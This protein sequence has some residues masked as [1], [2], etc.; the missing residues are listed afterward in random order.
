MRHAYPEQGMC[1]NITEQQTLRD[2]KAMP[3]QSRSALKAGPPELPPARHTA[4]LR[5]RQVTA[6]SARTP[7]P[8]FRCI[9]LE[10]DWKGAGIR[11]ARVVHAQPWSREKRSW[12][13][14]AARVHELL[15]H[16]GTAALRL[17][18]DKRRGTSMVGRS[19]STAA[20]QIC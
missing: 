11:C 15:A 10:H 6:T 14:T 1:I 8:A 18:V 5:S 12:D 3:Q 13:G 9:R 19:A 4:A 17:G 20:H 16:C 7:W 2:W